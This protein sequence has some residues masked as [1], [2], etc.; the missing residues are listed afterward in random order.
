[1]RSTKR[2]R[3]FHLFAILIAVAVLMTPLTLPGRADAR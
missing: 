1:M 3:L 2:I